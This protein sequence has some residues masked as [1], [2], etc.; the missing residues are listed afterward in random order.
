MAARAEGEITLRIPARQE[1]V[2]VIRTALGGAGLLMGL[3]IDRLDDLRTAAD[4]ACDYLLN[5]PRQ[6]RTLEMAC[7]MADGVME[8]VFTAQ[9]SGESQTGGRVDHLMARGIL[10]TLI[11]RVAFEED[12]RGVYQIRLGLPVAES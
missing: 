9:W 7:R 5:Q 10:E 8:T 1:N 11:P 2:L 4:E 6:A 3:D 12:A